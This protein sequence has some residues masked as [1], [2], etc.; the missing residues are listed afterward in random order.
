MSDKTEQPTPRRLRHAREQGDLAVSGALT[1]AV[2]FLVALSLVPSLVSAGFGVASRAVAYAAEGRALEPA[3]LALAV[4]T[5]TVPLLTA[6]AFTSWCVGLVQSGGAFV[7]SRLSLRLD[8]LNPLTGITGLFS[9]E[10]LVSV[11]R[12]LLA[13]GI[14]IALTLSVLRSH[15]PALAATPGQLGPALGLVEIVSRRIARDA[16]LVFLALGAL[17]LLLVRRAFLKRWMMTRAEV[18]RD[19]R[20]AEGNPELKAARRRAHQEVLFSA[21]LA[22]VERARV[23]IVNPTHL[24]TALGYDEAEDAAPTVLAQGQGALARQILDAARAAGVPVIRDVPVAR[25]LM[26]LEVGEE[27]PEALY[28]AVAEILRELMPAGD[29]SEP[30]T[31]EPSGEPPR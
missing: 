16:A 14:V 21:Q 24:A 19:F 11:L 30:S 22:A 8:R 26:D 25:A 12:A 28:E 2:A 20:E 7:P 4:L 23:V 18:Q 17:D 1:Q 31:P 15:L 10:R 9:A 29:A 3:E 6:A 27:I 13:A 5:V